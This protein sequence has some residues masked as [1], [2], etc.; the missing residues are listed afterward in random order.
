[1]K[2]AFIIRLYTKKSLKLHIIS[3]FFLFSCVHKKSLEHIYLVFAIKESNISLLIIVYLT[4]SCF[5][6]LYFERFRQFFWKSLSKIPS[7]NFHLLLYFS[8]FSFNLRKI[9][10]SK[11]LNFFKGI[12]F[13]EGPNFFRVWV[14]NFASGVKILLVRFQNFVTG[15]Q[16]FSSGVQTT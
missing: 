5:I 6:S 16:I 7:W 4:Q 1:M 8:K 9:K 3:D 15:G 13:S 14:N 2:I 11:Q 12:F 10:L